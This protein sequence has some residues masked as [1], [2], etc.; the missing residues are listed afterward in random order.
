MPL[1][2]ASLNP[3][4]RRCHVQSV[5]TTQSCSIMFCSILFYPVH[6]QTFQSLTQLST[7]ILEP[8]P[9]PATT[10]FDTPIHLSLGPLVS[11]CM[12]LNASSSPSPASPA[13]L[14]TRLLAHALSRLH[15]Y[16]REIDRLFM[17]IWVALPRFTQGILITQ[18]YAYIWYIFLEISFS[19]IR[20]LLPNIPIFFPI[21]PISPVFSGFPLLST[22][23]EPQMTVLLP[24][25]GDVR[26]I[27][28]A[29][30]PWE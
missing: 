26:R 9:P 13:C 16:R 1:C 20:L 7:R 27:N 6:C 17:L 3:Y 4:P 12:L 24:L 10:I 19:R 15:P 25:P 21:L 2:P 29:M 23:V 5:D 11:E 28:L 14:L 18:I 8:S 22:L 30:A